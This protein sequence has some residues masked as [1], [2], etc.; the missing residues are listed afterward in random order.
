MK[1]NRLFILLLS[2]LWVLPSFAQSLSI[3]TPFQ[4]GLS[5]RDSKYWSAFQKHD[6]PDADDKFP[7]AVISIKLVG[8]VQEA[9][10]LMEVFVGGYKVQDVI[11]TLPDE[12]VFLVGAGTNFVDVLCGDGVEPLKILN[13]PNSLKMEKIYE[14]T[15]RFT[16]AEELRLNTYETYKKAAEKL[17]KGYLTESE[18]EYF[19]K[20]TKAFEE[21][22]NREDCPAEDKAEL[23]RKHDEMKWIRL[24]TYQY[25]VQAAQGLRRNSYSSDSTFY[26]L[27][28]R[29]QIARQLKDKYPDSSGFDH[30]YHEALEARNKHPK[31]S[32]TS[33]VTRTHYRDSAYGKVTQK[34]NTMDYSMIGIYATKVREP[35]KDD[36]KLPLGRV[37]S[38]RTYNVTM[39]D[40]YSY[41]IFDSEKEAH[42]VGAPDTKIDVYLNK[43]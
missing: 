3:V 39:P 4:E 8:D 42:Y 5:V 14:G 26:W 41:I 10:K 23:K 27:Q 2:A 33:T 7:Y 15:L 16:L 32:T 35:K 28:V 30:M 31:A 25:Q 21:A 1:K 34:S 11:T 29:V 18:T 22:M 12:M 37:N 43:L 19:R 20:A 6:M 36:K 40:G 17:Y 9:K 24:K 38:D 13:L